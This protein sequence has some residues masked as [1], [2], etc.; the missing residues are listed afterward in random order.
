MTRSP[1][2]KRESFRRV[3]AVPK[4]VN[5]AFWILI[6]LE[7][8]HVVNHLPF[9]AATD[10]SNSLDE[11]TRDWEKRGFRLEA[12]LALGVYEFVWART[13]ALSG[14]VF[15][16]WVALLVR[17][18]VNWAR[19]VTTVS[20][21]IGLLYVFPLDFITAGTAAA[22]IVAVVLLWLPTSRAFFAAVRVERGVFKAGQFS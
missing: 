8:I 3:T 10:L 22:N 18:G 13:M 5:I 4:V 16:V 11:F 14:V 9:F 17:R 19:I 12:P 20:A 21:A 15:F 2:A 7:V 1:K 6:A